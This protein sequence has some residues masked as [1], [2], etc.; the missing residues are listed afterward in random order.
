MMQVKQITQTIYKLDVC[1][2]I[3]YLY[4]KGQGKT[5]K[6]EILTSK[7]ILIEFLFKFHSYLYILI[8]R[9]KK[10]IGMS[11]IYTYVNSTVSI[12]S[13]GDTTQLGFACQSNHYNWYH[14]RYCIKN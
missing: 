8:F 2:S 5:F 12:Y 1:T 13:S 6:L 14:T 11:E 3:K 9:A 7:K 10:E 4:V